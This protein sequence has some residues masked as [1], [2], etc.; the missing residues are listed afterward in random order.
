MWDGNY[1]PKPAYTAV[2]QTLGGGSGG[3]SGTGAGLAYTY[4]ANHQV[5]AADGP[6]QG[7]VR[8]QAK[9]P[10]GAGE[11]ATT[12][13]A[14]PAPSPVLPFNAKLTAQDI[15]VAGGGVRS[16]GCSGALIDP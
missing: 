14:P 9:S 7:E 10:A 5:N 12:L 8:G 11:D 13:P 1:Q 3:G 2:Q 16:G 4:S 6:A 15:P